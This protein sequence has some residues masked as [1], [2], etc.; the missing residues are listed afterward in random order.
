MFET[1][2]PYAF[3]CLRASFLWALSSNTPWQSDR[4]DLEYLYH[5]QLTELF[6]SEDDKIRNNL[7]LS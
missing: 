3:H 5:L 2:V 1:F 6:A 4:K 7:P